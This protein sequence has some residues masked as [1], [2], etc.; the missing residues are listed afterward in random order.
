MQLY[1]QADVAW[2][3]L[4]GLLL[5]LCTFFVQN[6]PAS[7]RARGAVYI[8]PIQN[9]ID[10]GIAPY[11]ARM[12]DEAAQ[13]GAQAVV[14][15]IDTPGGRLDAVLQMR[16]AI[17]DSPVPTVAYV[18][19][20]AFSAGALI[21]IAANEIYMAP[22]AVLGAATPVDGS[23]TT[24]DAKTISAVRSI[25]RAT[26]ELRGRDPL[27]AEA[28]VDPSLVINGLVTDAQLLTLTTAQA[29]EMGYI[30]G[31]VANREA[32]LQ[33]AGLADAAVVETVQNWA[34][35]SVRFLTNSI[36]AS[37]LLS[38]GFLLIFADV[39]TAGFGA[40]GLSGI[41]LIGLFFWGHFLVGL[42]GWEGVALVVVG[43]V[44]LALE[45]LV[46]PGFGVAGILGVITL[47]GGIFISL[48]DARIVTTA[49]LVRAGS[50]V[51]GTV[52]LLAG[53]SVL[54]VAFL[55]RS[56]R[57]QGLILQSKV[58]VSDAAILPKIPSKRRG[59][60]EGDRLEAH[61][62]TAQSQPATAALHSFTGAIGVA[63]SDLRPSGIAEIAGARVDV[64]SRGE[65]I[66]AGSAIEVLVD[67]GYRRVVRQVELR[68]GNQNE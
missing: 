5:F 10:L 57:M 1:R 44:L 49:D 56:A 43:L 14:L 60:L 66:A 34:E 28:M 39:Y 4:L 29:Q 63:R 8:V 12:L 13:A 59:W 3:R 65:Y 18:N 51:L 6:I 52:L 17:L 35:T 58:G 48:F 42:A 64:V 26:A 25:F 31:V 19:R 16:D 62:A 22:G 23:G 32:L 20:Q 27:I 53:G 36:V 2:L 21:A 54:L 68:P 9:E 30:D 24:A 38:I 50:T 33:A 45:V 41:A 7:A 67:E 47:L 37:L 61:N 55:P 15:D 40:L 11:L 46:I